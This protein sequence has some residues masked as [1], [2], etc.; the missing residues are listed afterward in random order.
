V[1]LH[2]P[3]DVRKLAALCSG[4]AESRLLERMQAFCCGTGCRRAALLLYFG[5]VRAPGCS[6]AC[7][8]ACGR[9]G[10]GAGGCGAGAGSGAGGGAGG[11]GGA[12]PAAATRDTRDLSDEARLLLMVVRASGQR[13]GLNV[14]VKILVGS[15]AKEV[16]SRFSEATMAA[17]GQGTP[18]G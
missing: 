4:P 2:A 1:L 17:W 16:A 3:A 13:F 15:K 8:D 12:A 14:P 11:R 7:C 9:A 5:E 6:A 10:G 18:R